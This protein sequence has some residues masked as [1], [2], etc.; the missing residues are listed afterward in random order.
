[1]ASI[2]PL[3]CSNKHSSSPVLPPYQRT[4]Q[5]SSKRARHKQ[6]GN[7]PNQLHALHK[8]NS[9]KMLEWNW[10][11]SWSELFGEPVARIRQGGGRGSKSCREAGN[12]SFVIIFISFFT[13]FYKSEHLFLNIFE[14]DLQPYEAKRVSCVPSRTPGRALRSRR[15]CTGS[16]AGFFLWSSKG[17]GKMLKSGKVFKK[18]NALVLLQVCSWSR[19]SAT[20]CGCGKV[21][22]IF[23]LSHVCNIFAQNWIKNYLCC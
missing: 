19:A 23:F 8:T 14:Q 7:I 18:N 2:D 17:C 5:R 1:M 9:L 10:K 20:L 21:Y 11:A 13:P 3:L 22:N 6:P 16:P 12:Q 15:Q 4:D